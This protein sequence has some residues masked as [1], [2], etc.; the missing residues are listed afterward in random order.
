MIAFVITLIPKFDKPKFRMLRAIL[1]VLAGLSSAIPCFHLSFDRNLYLYPFSGSLWI[2]GGALYIGGA[3]IYGLRFPE[4]FFP[5][6]FDFFG[7][8]HNIFHFCVLAA[9]VVHFF[10]SMSNYNGRRQLMC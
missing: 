10:A 5:K 3:L 2:I 7:S 6:R 9:A 1:Y 4:R 8:S